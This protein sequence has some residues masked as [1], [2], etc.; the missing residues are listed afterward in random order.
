MGRIENA[1]KNIRYGYL[2]VLLTLLLQFVSR[3]IFIHTIGVTFLG[4]SGLYTNVLSVLS[5][6]ELGIGTAMNFS[7]YKPVAEN[8]K[9]KIKSLMQLYKYAYRWIALVVT[10]FG[11]GVIPFLNF[12]IKEP[13]AITPNELIIYYVIFL[14]NTVST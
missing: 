5:F 14:F 6:A 3:T 13:G 10:V 4:V 11:L 2:G 12:I 7:L 9:D 8:D 1:S